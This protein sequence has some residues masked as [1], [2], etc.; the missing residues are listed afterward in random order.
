MKFQFKTEK[1]LENKKHLQTSKTLLAYLES[2]TYIFKTCLYT[3]EL[4]LN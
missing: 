3:T 4:N 2:E 1:I